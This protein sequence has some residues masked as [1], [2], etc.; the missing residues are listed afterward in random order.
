MVQLHVARVKISSVSITVLLSGWSVMGAVQ[1]AISRHPGTADLTRFG[2]S[3]I[4]AVVIGLASELLGSSTQIDR[5]VIVLAGI[6]PGGTT[7]VDRGEV[8]TGRASSER[9]VRTIGRARSG[10]P[11]G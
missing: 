6:V 10:R 5:H 4:A 11:C 3:T 7:H 9:R 1:D 8:L 2:I